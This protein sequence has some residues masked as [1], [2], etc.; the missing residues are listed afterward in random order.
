LGGVS[1]KKLQFIHNKEVL[2]AKV[3]KF[4]GSLTKDLQD[5]QRQGRKRFRRSSPYII[6][7]TGNPSS[8]IDQTR[9]L[10]RLVRLM[11][12]SSSFISLICQSF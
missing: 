10:Y 3:N 7:G 8:V 4:S 5:S 9:Y 12:T 11:S 2:I 1:V 6:L